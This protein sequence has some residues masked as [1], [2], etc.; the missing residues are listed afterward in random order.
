MIT[1]RSAA[2]FDPGGTVEGLGGTVP[3]PEWLAT[4]RSSPPAFASSMHL[5]A[6]PLIDLAVGAEEA[7]MDTYAVVFQVGARNDSGGDLTLGMR[8]VDHVVRRQER[9]LIHHRVATNVWMRD[10]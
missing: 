6:E 2:L 8:Y 1:T 5:L 9:W 10:R 7:A 3:V 4:R